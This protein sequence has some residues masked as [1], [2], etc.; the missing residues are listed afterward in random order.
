MYFIKA[1]EGENHWW[2]YVL[3]LI[4][5]TF[6][7]SVIGFIPIFIVVAWKSSLGFDVDLQ[8]FSQNYD[9]RAI[10]LEVN[11]GLILLLIPSVLGF[12]ALVYM[13]VKFH[14]KKLSSIASAGDKIRWDRILSGA[15]IWFILLVIAEIISALSFPENY[16]LQ[17]NPGQFIP[18]FFIALIFIPF[19]AW[20]EEL[21]FRGFLMQGLG[22]LFRYR[23]LALLATSIGFG[24]LHISNPEVKAL[25]FSSVMPYYIAFGLFSGLLVIMDNGLELALGVHAINNIFGAVF[26]TYKSSVLK[27]PALW[28]NR[29]INPL[30]MNL[31]FLVMAIVFV[32]IVSWKYK[33]EDWKKMF[34]LIPYK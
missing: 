27:T 25:G 12:F 30:L 11:S 34:R 8:A 15:F 20:F 9:P 22:L 5:V 14:K 33:W 31:A 19:Q 3:T 32:R 6:I 26:V 29:E 7:V 13:M 16:E 17:F 4:V 21:L 23:I 2:Q 28:I 10:G 1:R 18:L 24:M